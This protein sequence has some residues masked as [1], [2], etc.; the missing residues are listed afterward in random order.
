MQGIRA[1]LME[2]NKFFQ[3]EL[4]SMKEEISGE[5]RAEFRSEISKE[6]AARE[7]LENRVKDLTDKFEVMTTSAKAPTFPDRSRSWGP[8]TRVQDDHREELI[9]RTIVV[10]GFPRDTPRDSIVKKMTEITKDVEDI[11]EKAYTLSKRATLGFL[12][13]TSASARAAYLKQIRDEPRPSF[14]EKQLFIGPERNAADRQR[15]RP[16]SKVVNLLVGGGIPRDKLEVDFRMSVVWLDGI[17]G[18]IAEWQW[19]P[20]SSG[21]IFKINKEAIDAL[22]ND[23]T[24]EQI[25]KEVV[26]LTRRY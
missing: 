19:N 12:R 24:G 17:E 4:S 10:G 22:P 14:N 9:K 8:Q 13:F 25:D 6:R 11:E 21:E 5:L 3:K 20:E 1:L 7:E 15:A 26:W 18:R 16:L 23:L 2:Q